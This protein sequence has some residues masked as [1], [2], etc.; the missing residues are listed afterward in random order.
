MDTKKIRIYLN[1]IGGELPNCPKKSADWIENYLDLIF[2][3]LDKENNDGRGT[4]ED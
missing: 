4:S 3:E 1:R 2:I